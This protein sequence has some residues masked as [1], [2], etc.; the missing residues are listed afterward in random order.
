M[1]VF[2]Q[3]NF[4]AVKREMVGASQ[5]EIMRRMGELWQK[6]KGEKMASSGSREDNEA[7]EGLS[8]GLEQMEIEI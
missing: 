4:V 1:I 8:K 7:V 2:V 5:G 3:K 6:E